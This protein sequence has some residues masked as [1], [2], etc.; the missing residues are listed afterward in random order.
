M[1]RSSRSRPPVRRRQHSERTTAVFGFSRITREQAI[2]LAARDL[3]R[4]PTSV[5]ALR[6]IHLFH[7]DVDELAHAGVCYELLRALDRQLAF[8]F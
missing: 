3:M 7:L 4:S 8:R 5:Q 1:V 6:L 2:Q